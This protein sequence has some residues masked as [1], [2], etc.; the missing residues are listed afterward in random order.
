LRGCDRLRSS[1]KVGACNQPDPPRYPV[2]R[3]LRRNAAQTERRLRQRLHRA[4]W[5]GL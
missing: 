5:A 3:P 2:L 1:R 4:P